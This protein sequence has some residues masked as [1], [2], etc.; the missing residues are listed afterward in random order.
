[1]N[2]RISIVAIALLVVLESS[3]ANSTAPAIVPTPSALSIYQAIP[4]LISFIAFTA[5]QRTPLDGLV[6][7]I[8]PSGCLSSTSAAL[9]NR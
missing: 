9:C 7:K 1:M 6:G 8:S 4:N 3:W 5:A 2:R